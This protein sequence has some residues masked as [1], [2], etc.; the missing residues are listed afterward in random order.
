[1]TFD[2]SLDD[3]LG[4]S[5]SSAPPAKNK[6]G[7]P[8]KH[9]PRDP[10]IPKRPPGRPSTRPPKPPKT[11]PLAT[12]PTALPELPVEVELPEIEADFEVET[13]T[14]SSRI[15]SPRFVDVGDW[16]EALRP[17][18]LQW[19]SKAFNIP[20]DTVKLKLAD[21]PSIGSEGGK[22]KLY[23]FR[24]AAPYLVKPKNVDEFIKGLKPADLP[25]SLRK[26]TYQALIMKQ[27]FMKA[28]GELWHTSQV[29]EVFGEAMKNIKESMQLWVDKLDRVDGMNDSQRAIITALVDELQKDIY[30]SLVK[31]QDVNE[32]PS[33][34]ADDAE[35]LE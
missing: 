16:S 6:G 19:L 4:F 24:Q 15:Q 14:K 20:R 27:R 30:D 2:S 29:F 7:R 17:V 22:S 28:A 10:S 26:E 25:L 1:M 9:P 33:S 11:P 23:D 34:V 18:S 3:L 35:L 8:R 5:E 21:L 12:A 31:M 13:T 32:T